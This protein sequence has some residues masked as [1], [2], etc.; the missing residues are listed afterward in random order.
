MTIAVLPEFR[1]RGIGKKLMIESIKRAIKRGA[2]SMIFEVR[3]DNYPALHIYKNF[4]FKIIGR[5]K[6]YYMG[7]EDAFTM[8]ADFEDLK[9]KLPLDK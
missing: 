2:K 1:G 8:C 3:V 7:G 6:D 5:I 4:G 9:C